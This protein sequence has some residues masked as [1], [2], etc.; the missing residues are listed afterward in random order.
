MV[1]ANEYVIAHIQSFT[2]IAKRGSDRFTIAI[3]ACWTKHSL[4]VRL[5][6]VILKK[7]DQTKHELLLLWYGFVDCTGNPTRLGRVPPMC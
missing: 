2:R 4:N 1:I 3:I 7:I 6:T 5:I